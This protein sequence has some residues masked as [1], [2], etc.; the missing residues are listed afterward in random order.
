[1]GAIGLKQVDSLK[2]QLRERLEC[3][4]GTRGWVYDTQAACDVRTPVL[5]HLDAFYDPVVSG[6]LIMAH[7]ARIPRSITVETYSNRHLMVDENLRNLRR[8]ERCVGLHSESYFGASRMS[9][10]GAEERSEALR[11][12]EHRL[13]S[14]GVHIDMMEGVGGRVFSYTLGK[15]YQYILW[16]DGRHRFP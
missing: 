15:A 2:P 10:D 11:T 13:A 8:R 3:A 1:M 5:Q 6:P 12:Q 7:S 14:M 4:S 16:D 9:P